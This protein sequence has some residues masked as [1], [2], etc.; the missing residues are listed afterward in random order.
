VGFHDYEVWSYRYRESGVWNSM[1]HVHFDQAGVVRQM[2]N[3]PDPRYQDHDRD[4]W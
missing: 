2:L 1:M 4:F 3:G